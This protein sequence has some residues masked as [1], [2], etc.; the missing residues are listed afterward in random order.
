MNDSEVL[1]VCQ[2]LLDVNK[3]KTLNNIKIIAKLFKEHGFNGRNGIQKIIYFIND[4]YL[5]N[6]KSKNINVILKA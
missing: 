3:E 5:I 4:K 1:I 2:F 6:D